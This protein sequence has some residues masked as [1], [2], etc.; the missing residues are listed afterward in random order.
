VPAAT[1]TRTMPADSAPMAPPATTRTA[2]RAGVSTTTKQTRYPLTGAHRALQCHGCHTSR[3]VE[4]VSAPDTC[5][6]CHGKDDVHDGAFG[7][8]CEKCH[9]TVSFRQGLSRQ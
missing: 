9:T 4:K 1:P 5:Y 7:R 8:A 2:G 3:A 6:A